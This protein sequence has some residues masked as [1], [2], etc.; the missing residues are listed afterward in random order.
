MLR[1][2]PLKKSDLGRI[3]NIPLTNYRILSLYR[4]REGESKRERENKV[5]HYG[6][7]LKHAVER[8]NL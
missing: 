5:L 4:K 8:K 1:P 2:N 3:L 7:A 6:D